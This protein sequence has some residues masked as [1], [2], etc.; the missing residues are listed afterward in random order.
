MAEVL[1]ANDLRS[2]VDRIERL[3]EETSS[4][5]DAKKDILQEAKDKGFEPKFIKKIVSLRKK[6][7]SELH[8]EEAEFDLYRQAFGL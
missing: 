2:I 4:L 7:L 5:N 1:N 6:S 3:N 8:L